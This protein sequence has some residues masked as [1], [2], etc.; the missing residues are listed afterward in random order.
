[1]STA[2]LDQT[3]DR[4]VRSDL[5]AASSSKI[6]EARSR[7]L[8]LRTYAANGCVPIIDA[9]AA[10]HPTAV[11]IGDVRIGPDCWVGPNATLR[12]DQGRIV[13]GARTSIQDNCVLHTGPDG[14]LSIDAEGQIGHGAMLH[15]CTIGRNVLI[16]MG[17]IVLGRRRRRARRRGRRRGAGALQSARAGR[18]AVRRFS[19]QGRSRPDGRRPGEQAPM[20]GALRGT[21]ARRHRDELGA[22]ADRR[23]RR[24][25]RVFRVRLAEPAPVSASFAQREPHRRT[26]SARC[27]ADQQ[28]RFS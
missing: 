9:S 18:N 3:L 27:A 16:G 24:G 13:I 14:S 25:L 22:G 10:V 2:A 1:M 4:A 6:E 26:A 19:R 8:Y 7:A 11:L 12:A 15:G 28:P 21:C 20:H 23:H 5:R 17:A